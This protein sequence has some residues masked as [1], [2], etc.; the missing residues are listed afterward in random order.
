MRRPDLLELLIVPSDVDM[1]T[2]LM[3]IIYDLRADEVIIDSE[4]IELTHLL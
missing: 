3:L 4:V 2:M 1:I